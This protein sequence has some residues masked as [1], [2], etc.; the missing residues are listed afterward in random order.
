[1]NMKLIGRKRKVDF[2]TQVMLLIALVGLIIVFSI[3]SPVFFSWQNFI[4]VGSYASIMAV[5]AAGL[6]FAMIVGGLDI[7]QYSIVALSGMLTGML[8]AQG[9]SAFIVLPL[10]LLAGMIIG[11]INAFIITKMRIN[12]IIATLGTQ[13]VFRSIAFMVLDGR[14]I[15]VDDP[16]FNFI[17][18]GNL[19]GVPFTIWIMVIVYIIVFWIF[20]YTVYGRKL[21]AVGGNPEASFLSGININRIRA[22]AYIISGLAAAIGGILFSS[23]VGAAMPSAGQGSELDVIISV[24][25]GGIG[26]AGG[27]G[28]ISGTLL[29]VLII[30]ILRNGMTL[31][32]V[33]AFYQMFIRGLVLIFA[34]YLD[35]LRGGGYK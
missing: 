3:L 16:V 18:R 9:I 24:I 6:T 7:S 31:L 20:K 2:N 13:L 34:V 29:G 30:A 22:N 28:K 33:Q 4:N 1:M 10:M 32:N 19:L 5:M 12:P 27:K 35:S 14:Y 26:L 25:L 17:G 8:L 21:F 23:Q 15:Q 11:F